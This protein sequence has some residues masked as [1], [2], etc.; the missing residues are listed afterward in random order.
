MPPAGCAAGGVGLKKP[1][2]PYTLVD[3]AGASGLHGHPES[4]DGTDVALADRLAFGG[5]AVVGGL[6]CQAPSFRSKSAVERFG[7]GVSP[8]FPGSMNK[9]PRLQARQ[10]AVKP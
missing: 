4:G 10:P 6:E 8:R 9:A 3:G 1:G 7:V 5:E 2:L